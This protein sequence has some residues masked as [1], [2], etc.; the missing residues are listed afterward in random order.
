[1]KTCNKCNAIKDL[2]E[3]FK[4]KGFKDGHASICK[5]CKNLKTQEW[6]EKNREQYNRNMRLYRANNQGAM[7]DTDLRRTHGISLEDYNKMLAEQ[8]G[9]CKMCK[10]ENTSFKRSFAVDHN[11]ETGHVRALLCY[12][13]NRALHALETKSLLKTAQEYLEEYKDPTGRPIS[14]LTINAKRTLK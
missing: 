4:D 3:F 1:M 13:C 6:K 9:R 7:K 2:V 8:E 11:H 10:K 5:V 14:K 12:G